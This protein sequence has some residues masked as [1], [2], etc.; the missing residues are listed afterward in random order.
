MKVFQIYKDTSLFT[1]RA[2]FNGQSARPSPILEPF[3]FRSKHLKIQSSSIQYHHGRIIVTSRQLCRDTKADIPPKN[4]SV[5]HDM[6]MTQ[7]TSTPLLPCNNVI[8]WARHVPLPGTPTKQRLFCALLDILTSPTLKDTTF[9]EGPYFPTTR[10]TTAAQAREILT[11]AS[12]EGSK[13]CYHREL[14]GSELRSLRD[15]YGLVDVIPGTSVAMIAI[16]TWKEVEVGTIPTKY[17]RIVGRLRIMDQHKQNTLQVADDGQ[18]PMA[19]GWHFHWSTKDNNHPGGIQDDLDWKFIVAFLLYKIETTWDKEGGIKFSS[20]ET[21]RRTRDMLY[22]FH[23]LGY[24]GI[25]GVSMRDKVCDDTRES[26]RRVKF[27]RGWIR[28]LGKDITLLL[29]PDENSEIILDV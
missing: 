9:A 25:P 20:E 28:E 27:D 18:S 13:K 14:R 12:F 17:Y 2:E 19:V 24:F 5:D 8:S 10:N 6:A 23:E 7:S 21:N 22:P 3:V 4:S 1:Q 15:H 16:E 29:G 26:F 11:R